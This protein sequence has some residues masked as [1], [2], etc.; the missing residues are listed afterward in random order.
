MRRDLLFRRVPLLLVALVLSMPLEAGSVTKSQVDAACADSEAAYREFQAAQERFVAA[1]LAYEEAANDVAKVERKQ[2]VIAGA[3]E[4]RLAAREDIAAAAQQKAVEM[5]MRGAAASPG[6]LL[7]LASFGE[8]M[9]TAE[10]LASASA[11]DQ[12]S[13]RELAAMEA[14]LTRFQAELTE[15]EAEL[16]AIE[17]QRLDVMA[18]Q[19]EA[20]NATQ[21]AYAKLSERCKELN[22]QYEAALAEARAR[23]ERER[24]GR[25]GGASG[26]SAA[27]TPGFI[28]PMTPG[29]TWFI[30]SWGFPRSGGRTH[31]GTDLMA[32]WNE[33][34]YAVASG[35]VYLGNSRLG[36][37][38]I[39][40]VS[41]HGTAYYYAHLADFAVG[42]GARVGRGQTV[43]YNGDSGNARGGAPHLHFQIHPGGRGS[44]AVNPYPTLA[45]A[46][47]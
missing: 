1:S 34:I 30:D 37:K 25:G 38:T 20:R 42:N 9:T 40:L 18:A 15:V 12:A 6:M 10:F 4:A 24:Q 31:K 45:R 35:T 13:L 32:A 44:P 14:D 5:Y 22:R 8:A 27:A 36:G 2:V 21:A 47:F 33:P 19:E 7:S 39:W 46:C 29:R 28:C 43:G 41:D 3:I 26:V 23:A 11:D 17:A 16:R